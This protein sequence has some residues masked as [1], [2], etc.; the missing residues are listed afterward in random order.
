MIER[1]LRLAGAGVG[2][3]RGSVWAL[4]SLG[5]R[6]IWLCC[7]VVALAML[8]RTHVV[9]GPQLSNDS[10]QYLS[11]AENFRRGEPAM[12][13]IAHFDAE[14]S[15]GRIPAPLTTFPA[16]YPALIAFVSAAGLSG[17]L[18]GVLVSMLAAIALVAM[19]GLATRQLGM[20][21]PPAGVLIALLATSS[22]WVVTGNQVASEALFTALSF[23]ALLVL[24]A[25]ESRERTQRDY[26]QLQLAANVLIAAAFW[27]RYAGLFLF[28][29]TACFHALR[30]LT[31]RTR[32]P[33]YAIGAM[34][35]SAALIGAALW[36]NHLLV[37]SWKG[38]NTKEVEN[39]IVELSYRFARTMYQV[40]LGHRPAELG[41]AEAVLALA[42]VAILAMGLRALWRSRRAQYSDPRLQLLAIYIAVYSSAMLYLGARSVISFG[43]RMFVPLLPVLLLFVGGLC[44]NAAPVLARPA[45]AWRVLHVVAWILVAAYAA[46]NLRFLLQDPGTLP[47]ERVQERLVAPAADGR[48]LREW[49]E[50]EVSPQATL[51][52]TDGQATGYVLRRKVLSLVSEQYSDRPWTEEAVREEMTRFGARHLL[53]HV[54]PGEAGAPAHASAFLGGLAGGAAPAWLHLIADNGRA[55]LFGRRDIERQGEAP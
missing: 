10:Y 35:L 7:L 26:V 8:L 12:T 2:G 34:S 31:A 38:G 47:H 11:T 54:A 16:G 13:S 44:C 49:I 45:R 50:G 6:E 36:R 5:A 24:I 33:Y 53:V 46:V 29:A 1:A 37:G 28:A 4:P 3:R 42:L 41:I 21:A 15:H 43:P 19:F 48:S 27:V 18:S 51:A 55:R 25:A 17:E 9:G 39:G 22:T 32:R 52:A 20:A 30:W 23:G 40:F 14:R